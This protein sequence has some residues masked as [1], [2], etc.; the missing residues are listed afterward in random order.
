[1]RA[2]NTESKV[3][4]PELFEKILSHFQSKRSRFDDKWENFTTQKEKNDYVLHQARTPLIHSKNL[5]HKN[6][7]EKQIDLPTF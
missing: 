7:S 6:K 4:D 2:I 5:Q 1:V 3:F